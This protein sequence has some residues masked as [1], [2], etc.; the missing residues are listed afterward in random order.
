MG[1]EK[2]VFVPELQQ[3]IVG[4]CGEQGAIRRYFQMAQ[5]SVKHLLQ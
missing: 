1:K 3:K 2:E 4:D 5:F